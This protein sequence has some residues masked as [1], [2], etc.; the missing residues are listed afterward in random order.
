MKDL[1]KFR[2]ALVIFVLSI[3]VVMA[4]CARN[5]V[6]DESSETTDDQSTAMEADGAMED[7]GSVEDENSMAEGEKTTDGEA[8]GEAM[9]DKQD[10]PEVY[11]VEDK[12]DNVDNQDMVGDVDVSLFARND[13][14]QSGLAIFSRIAEKTKISIRISNPQVIELQPAKI[15]IGSCLDPGPAKHIL[16]NLVNGVSQTII[17]VSLDQLKED[18]PLAVMI[19]KSN[20]DSAIV[21]SCGL[22]QF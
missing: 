22:I 18:L 8:A 9:T 17:G 20:Q 13:S 11:A 10:Q 4:G 3:V 6:N 1:Y 15:V 12:T 14:G 5:E 19:S 21:T 7:E 16:N 2:L